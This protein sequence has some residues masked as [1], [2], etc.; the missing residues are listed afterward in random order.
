MANITSEEVARIGVLARLQLT[1]DEIEHFT[2]QL[3][4]ILGYFQQLQGLDTD[5]V[6]VTS[7]SVHLV[8]VWREDA[9]R[10]SL[11]PDEAVAGAPESHD[12][13]FIVPTIV[14]MGGHA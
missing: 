3:D 13:L 2:P 12:G 5:G 1:D 4:E 11:T 14:D 7:H 8:N 10:P 9:A 6:P